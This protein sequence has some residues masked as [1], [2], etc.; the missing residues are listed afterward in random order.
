MTMQFADIARQ[1]ATAGAITPEDVLAL[2]RAGWADGVMKPD[3]AEAAFALNDALAEPTAEWSDF[4]VEA[5]GE[6]VLNGTEPKGYVSDDNARW[7]IE[8]I[9]R[10]GLLQGMT[11]LQLLVRVV[12]LAFNVPKHLKG[13]ILDQVERAVLT[14]NGPTRSSGEFDAGCVTA[15]EATILRRILFARAGDAP[16][17]VSC[18]EAEFLFRLKDATRAMP[19]APEW[20]QLFAQGVGNYLMGVAARNSQISREREIELEAEIADNSSSVSGFL[21]RLVGHTPETFVALFGRGKGAQRSAL[22]LEVREAVL[23]PQRDRFAEMQEGERITADEQAWLDAQV[24]ADG[25]ID[26]YEQALIAFLAG[27]AA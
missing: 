27:E 26:E 21:G 14:G 12:E 17:S 7:L 6:F 3:E 11:E 19:N 13:Y 20:K 18:G 23:G 4:F 15:A 5:I 22:G 8:R 10:D 2:R 25:E 1:V 16:G 9:D 24:N